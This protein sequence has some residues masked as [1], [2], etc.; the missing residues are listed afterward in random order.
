MHRLLPALLD[1]TQY[2]IGHT[3]SMSMKRGTRE[4]LMVVLACLSHQDDL[5][6]YVLLGYKNIIEDE[7]PT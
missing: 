7:S 6:P 1:P 4:E 5:R 2:Y 3:C